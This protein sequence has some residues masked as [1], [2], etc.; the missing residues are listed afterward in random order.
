MKVAD[1]M[2]RLW[3]GKETLIIVSSDLSHYKDYQTAQKLDA[4]TSR[5]I[6][7]L[8]PQQ[9][10]SEQACGLIPI[11]GLLQ[12]AKQYNMQA[13]ALDVRNSGD[14]VGSRDSVVGYGA[15]CFW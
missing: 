15:Y 10:H 12:L 9:L 7:N 4:C 13:R 1:V 3:G 2:A 14:I 6:L 5:A 11:Q 8:A